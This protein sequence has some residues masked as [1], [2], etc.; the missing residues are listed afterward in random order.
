M[1]LNINN[2]LLTLV[3]LIIVFVLVLTLV[4]KKGNENFQNSLP[5]IPVN[6]VPTKQYAQPSETRNVSPVVINSISQFV[7]DPHTQ[8]NMVQIFE[9]LKNDNPCDVKSQ[10]ELNYKKME[11]MHKEMKEMKESCKL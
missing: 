4:T 6:N 10:L 5:S 7:P 8:E 11:E 9:D 1:K 2:D 3:L